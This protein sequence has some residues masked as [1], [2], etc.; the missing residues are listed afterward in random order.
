MEDQSQSPL[1]QCRCPGRLHQQTRLQGMQPFREPRASE[2]RRLR[3]RSRGEEAGS[4][5]DG[6]VSGAS[7]RTISPWAQ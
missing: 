4:A 6:T 5:R 2:R 7:H 3:N 1:E